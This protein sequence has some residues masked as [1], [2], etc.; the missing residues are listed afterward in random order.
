MHRY[1]IIGP[2]TFLTAETK[3]EAENLG[4]YLAVLGE[5][6]HVFVYVQKAEASPQLGLYLEVS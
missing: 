5:T 1:I 4:S 6:I 2:R 3:T